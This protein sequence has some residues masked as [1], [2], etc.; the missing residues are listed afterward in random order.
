[1]IISFRKTHLRIWILLSLILPILIVLAVVQ[2]PQYPLSRV[3]NDILPLEGAEVVYQND[4]EEYALVVRTNEDF[5]QLD[6][7]LKSALESPG[8]FLYGEVEGNP[9]IPLGTVGESGHYHIRLKKEKNTI[10]GL[11]IK[12]DLQDTTIMKIKF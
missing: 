6:L 12:D 4:N 3:D 1:M 5:W 7:H 8:P 2:T 11:T 9:L 10:T